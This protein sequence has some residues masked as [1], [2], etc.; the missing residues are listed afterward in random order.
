MVILNL[1]L[2]H[3]FYKK[4]ISRNCVGASPAKAD[5]FF[6]L[7]WLLPMMMSFCTVRILFPQSCISKVYYPAMTAILADSVETG[8]RTQLYTYR[9]ML[10]M[11]TRAIGPLMAALLFQFVWGNTWKLSSVRNVFLAG[12]IGT[13]VPALLLFFFDDKR[14]LGNVS[15]A[16]PRQGKSK[17]NGEKPDEAQP[18]IN[19]AF[20]GDDSSAAPSFPSNGCGCGTNWIP[21]LLAFSDLM[22][23]LGQGM[24]VKYF[25]IYFAEIV[26]LSPTTAMIV[27]ALGTVAAAL[28]SQASGRMSRAFGR[29]QTLIL[30][31]LGGVATMV[32][33]GFFSHDST[34]PDDC[35]RSTH[36]N[37]TF[38][39]ASFDS[40]ETFGPGF[41]GSAFDEEIDYAKPFSTWQVGVMVLFVA[42][43]G[44]FNSTQPLM[45]SIL[46]D[47]VPKNMRGR[48]S[49]V[50][51]LTS[52]GWSVTTIFGS[53][54][55]D[56]YCYS[57]LFY[58]TAG[59]M[60]LSQLPFWLMLQLVPKKEE[61]IR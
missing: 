28:F 7:A 55:V 24:T 25:Y 26:L 37:K 57:Y 30:F 33:L 45:K 29:V 15:E 59:C 51:S 38:E 3:C 46:M 39:D 19:A 31:R 43:T 18:L 44:F 36:R 8:A 9:W 58:T 49:A 53:M 35:G 1:S 5:I 48:W 21:W 61:S 22:F 17:R 56:A 14:T 32:A 34:H 42:Q 52:F 50:D 60:L 41:S 27:S 13:A 11:A 40:L 12:I 2:S 16:V 47:Y 54:I 4:I 6:Q 20:G 23:C 10:Q